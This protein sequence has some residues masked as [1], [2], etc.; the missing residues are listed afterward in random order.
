MV[1]GILLIIDIMF[2]K[3]F[4][5]RYY[6]QAE[7]NTQ[8]LYIIQKPLTCMSNSHSYG[9]IKYFLSPLGPIPKPRIPLDIYV[10]MRI[11]CDEN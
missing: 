10:A 2:S 9:A 5:F 3:D 7:K 4:V 1:D 11:H 8:N 6:F